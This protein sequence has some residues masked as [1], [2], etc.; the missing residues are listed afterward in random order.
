VA[1]GYY[2]YQ[3]E[4]LPHLIRMSQLAPVVLASFPLRWHILS[5][6]RWIRYRLLRR[7][8][9]RFYSLGELKKLAEHVRPGAWDIY[10]LGRDYLLHL[11]PPT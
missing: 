10:S 2:D 11:H 9:L 8:F 1:L 4:P 6:Q 5:P 3:R 7:C